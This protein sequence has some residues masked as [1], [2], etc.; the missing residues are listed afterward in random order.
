MRLP[1]AP[2][3]AERYAG[4]SAEEIARIADA[5]CAPRAGSI[6][7]A[8]LN[9]EEQSPKAKAEFDRAKQ[10]LRMAGT[11]AIR[12]NGSPV[13]L[14]EAPARYCSRSL[15]QKI[16]AD[17]IDY[18]RAIENTNLSLRMFS[19]RRRSISL[20]SSRAT[21]QHGRRSARSRPI[22]ASSRASKA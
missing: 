6:L 9:G 14:T 21:N 19:R 18:F 1:A 8:P 22:R 15:R 17:V 12:T 11:S 7:L 13:S 5:I 10:A 20:D 16:T 2:P 3:G 4:K